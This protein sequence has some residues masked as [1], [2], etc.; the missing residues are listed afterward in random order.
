MWAQEPKYFYNNQEYW[1]KIL[2]ESIQMAIKRFVEEEMLGNVSLDFLVSY[3]YKVTELKEMLRLHGIPLSGKKDE[4]IKRI[5]QADKESME[6]LVAGTELL[7][8]TQTGREIAKQYKIS[9]KEQRNKVEQEVF[10]YLTKRML[11]EASMLAANYIE[12]LV[13]SRGLGNNW[14]RPSPEFETEILKLI[15]NNKPY[16]LSK[17]ED[18]KLEVLRMSAAMMELWGESTAIKWLPTDFETGLSIDNDSTARMLL[19]NAMSITNLKQYKES[20]LK[21]IEVLGASNSC[22]IC[23]KIAGK[24][25]A[26]NEAPTL[27]NPNCTHE[28]GCRCVY[29]PCID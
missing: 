9:E 28:L 16:I 21:Y 26:I 12:E 15:F 2:N 11:Y 7:I 8:C 3:K 6:K 27:P 5:I 22:P 29:L 4:L 24:R 1:G 10:N 18:T 13:E 14:K 23:N 25:Y 17:L 19:F 20:G